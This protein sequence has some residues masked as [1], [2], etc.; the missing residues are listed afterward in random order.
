MY[1]TDCATTCWRRCENLDYVGARPD[2]RAG[3]CRNCGEA[4]EFTNYVP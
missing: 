2:Q 1:P 3:P 4:K